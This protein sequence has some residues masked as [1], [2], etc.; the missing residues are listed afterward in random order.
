VRRPPS[1][2]P[3][4]EPY[5]ALA[6]LGEETCARLEAGDE[7]CLVE[8]TARRDALLA[9]IVGIEVRPDEIEE[10]SSAIRHALAVDR[11]LLALLESRREAARQA[12]AQAAESRA[13][14]QSYRGPRREGSRYIE[15]LT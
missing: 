15:R 2:A 6:R 9:G 10:V 5:R 8:A 7:A 4:A 1:G 13:A 14:L 3:A 12:L 11:R